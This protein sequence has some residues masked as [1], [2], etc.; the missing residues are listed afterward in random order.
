[1]QPTFARTDTGVPARHDWWP[2]RYPSV[3]PL[4]LFPRPPVG[5]TRESTLPAAAL[6]LLTVGLFELLPAH[7]KPIPSIFV[8]SINVL[9]VVLLVVLVPHR[10]RLVERWQRSLVMVVMA[11]ISISNVFALGQLLQVLLT[12]NEPLTG[13]ELILSA[14][15]IWLTNVIIFGLWYWELDSG[16]P[17]A[18]AAAR[19]DSTLKRYPDFQYPQSENPE[20]APPTWHPRLLDYVYFSFTNGTAFSA[21]DVMPLSHWAKLLMMVQAGVS[22]LLIV[23]VTA[24][25]VSVL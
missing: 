4:R 20:L 17:G 18:R 7:F 9:L 16:G 5:T 15:V 3:M 1:M 6:V 2:A 13:R 12:K 25:A 11:T 21:A 8:I 19:D 10:H 22:L 24:R 14:A 23:L